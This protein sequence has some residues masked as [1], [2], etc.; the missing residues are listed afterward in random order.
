MLHKA[1]TLQPDNTIYKLMYVRSI[2]NLEAAI[3]RQ[4]E[5]EAAPNVAE[6]FRGAGV[7]NNYFREVL[8][9]VNETTNGS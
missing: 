9:R 4:A 2:P 7:L 5:R 8:S 6:T 1:T 3:Y